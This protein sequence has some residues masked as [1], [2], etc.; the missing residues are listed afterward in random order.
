MF[1]TLFPFASLNSQLEDCKAAIDEVRAT[2]PDAEE[3]ALLDAALLRKQ[4]KSLEEQFAVLT[5]CFVCVCVRAR[6][7]LGVGVGC[8]CVCVCVCV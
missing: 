2:F 3:P 8:S 1:S 6:V 5:V 4:K 7:M